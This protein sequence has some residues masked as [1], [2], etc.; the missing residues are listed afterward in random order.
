[1]KRKLLLLVL[2]QFIL[3]NALWAQ[4]KPTHPYIH[5]DC[6]PIPD[7]CSHPIVYLPVTDTIC[8]NYNNAVPDSIYLPSGFTITNWYWSP[9]TVITSAQSGT[10]SPAGITAT[11]AATSQTVTLYY[12][13]QGSNLIQN[14]DFVNPG[15]SCYNDTVADYTCFDSYYLTECGSGGDDYGH[16]KVGNNGCDVGPSPGMPSQPC[17][18][19]DGHTG[20]SPNLSLVVRG[21]AQF[22][23]DTLTN[24]FWGEPVN[25]CSGQKYVFTYWLRMVDPFTDTCTST[26]CLPEIKVYTGS[27]CGP[28]TLQYA[29][30][31]SATLIDD[32]NV[33]YQPGCDT[34]W[35]YVSDTFISNGGN[36]INM[37]CWRPGAT[38]FAIDDI[39]LIRLTY[40]STKMTVL[41]YA[42]PTETIAASTNTPCVGSNVTFTISNGKVGDVL[43][44]KLTTPSGGTTYT[45]HTMTA[46][47]W[48]LTTSSSIA[49]AGSFVLDS[50]TEAPPAGCT[51]AVNLSSLVTFEPKPTIIP[52][53]IEVCVGQT[54]GTLNF[55]STGSPTSYSLSWIT[56]G[57]PYSSG[58]LTNPL[59]LTVNSGTPGLYWGQLSVA[60][61]Y[62]C[63]SAITNVYLRV[64]PNPAAISLSQSA[65]CVGSTLTATD[66]TAG[67]AWSFQNPPGDITVSGSG[68][69]T[70]T[71]AGTGIVVYTLPTGCKATAS[72]TVN[73]LP[74]Q[75][76][77]T[78]S[79][80]KGFTTAPLFVGQGYSYNLTWSGT[81][82]GQGFVNQAIG[83][84]ASGVTYNVPIPVN[85]APG[86][87]TGSLTVTNTTTGCFTTIAVTIT[88]KSLPKSTFGSQVCLNSAIQ[89]IDTPSSGTFAVLYGSPDVAV[90]LNTGLLVGE[91]V[92]TAY[93]AYTAPNG[94]KDTT[95]ITVNPLPSPGTITTSNGGSDFCIGTNLTLYESN[96]SGYW[97]SA[98]PSVVTITG[99]T[100]SP[101]NSVTTVHAASV[102]YSLMTYTDSNI[103]HCINHNE[104]LL[105]VDTNGIAPITGALGV[106]QGYTTQLYD[107]TAGGVWSSNNTNV[108]TVDPFSGLVTGVN[109]G[110]ATITY[111]LNNTCGNYSTSVTL[112]T[113][114]PPYIT[115]HTTVACQSLGNDV[116]D[117]GATNILSDTSGCVKVCERSTV[118]YY[119]NGN[120]GSAYT[121]QVTGGTIVH[122]WGDSIDVQWNS[123]GVPAQITLLDS[124][125]SCNGA[126]SIC[127]NIILRP[128]AKFSILPDTTG[129]ITNV[130]ICRGSTISFKDLSIGDPNSPI[131]SWTWFFGD[132]G[133]SAQENPSYT[134]NT[135]GSFIAFLVVKNACNCTDTFTARINVISAPAPSITCVSVQCQNN[136]ATYQASPG[137]GSTWSVI[138]G[139]I[140][141]GNGTPNVTVYWNN[142]NPA[143]GIGYVSVIDNCQGCP[144]PAT[145]QVPVIP[146][147]SV[148][149]GPDTICEG[150][151]Y[152]YSLPLSPGTQYQ[153]GLLGDPTGIPG[154]RNDYKVVVTADNTGSFTLHGWFQNSIEL[155]GGNVDKTIVVVP[156]ATITGDLTPCYGTAT[157][158]TINGGD[159][160]PYTWTLAGPNAVT[161]TG[162]GSGTTF[163]PTFWGA[164]EYILSISGHYCTTPITINV[165]ATPP[166]LTGINGD[167]IVCLHRVYSYTAFTDSPGSVINWNIVGGTI[168]PGSGNTVTVVWNSTGTK[169]LTAYRTVIHSPFCPGT[170]YTLNIHQELINPV[171]T[172]DNAPCANS[173]R[174][175]TDNYTRG[176]TYQWSISPSTAG[177]VIAGM[178]SPNCNVM[179]NN[180]STVTNATLS[181]V[182]SKCDSTFTKT[183]AV[184]VQPS[185]IPFISGPITPVCPGTP[186]TFTASA[187]AVSYLWNFGDGTTD[188][189]TT[190]TD[191]HAF[192]LN[193]TTS[194][195]VYTVKVSL[196]ANTGGSC[197]ASGTAVMQVTVKPGP[198]AYVSAATDY[199]YQFPTT[200]VGTVTNNV[201]GF[202]YQWYDDNI[203]IPGTNQ[204]TYTATDSGSYFFVVT[205]SNGCSAQSNNLPLLIDSTIGAPCDTLNLITV[206]DS[207]SC[208]T[209]YLTGSGPY[210]SPTWVATTPPVGG[211]IVT[212]TYTAQATYDKPGIYR[213]IF[214]EYIDTCKNRIP[215]FDTI[216]FVPDFNYVVN[217]SGGGTSDSLK[218]QDHTAYLPNYFIDSIGWY[219]GATHIG[220]GSNLNLL[221]AAPSSYDVTEKVYVTGP[222]GISM[223]EKTVSIVLPAAPSI[224]FT[225]NPNAICAGVPIN[226]TPTNT[227]GFVSYSWNFGDL[228]SSLLQNTQR[229]Y[230]Y[231]GPSNPSPE[232]VVLTATNNIGCTATAT[233]TIH[234]YNNLIAGS[235][236]PGSE[237]VCAN[238]VPYIT[239]AYL[240][241]LGSSAPVSYLWSNTDNAPTTSV[242]QT[243]AYWV[244]VTDNHDCQQV[245][246]TSPAV[247]VKINF[248]HTPQATIS[249]QQTYC[250]GDVV[251]LSGYA[252][253]GVTYHWF[254]DSVPYTTAPIVSDANL[255]V[256]DYYYQLI[257]TSTDT[258]D[259]VTCSDT[260]AIFPVHIYGLPQPPTIS[261]PTVIDC[262]SYHLQLSASE[263]QNGTY[264]WSNGAQGATADI[265]SGG[266]YQ[267]WFTNQYGCVSE[268]Q[269]YV[270]LAPSY[271]FQYFPSGCYSLCPGLFPFTLDGPPIDTFSYW[272][273][274]N[275]GS[276]V[277]DGSGLM[278]PY[279]I[280]GDGSYSWQLDNGLCTQQSDKMDISENESCVTCSVKTLVNVKLTCVSG[281][282]ASFKLSLTLENTSANTTYAVGTDEGP[283][284]P[285]SGIMTTTGAYN[286][287]LTFTTL[288]T[289]P[290]P[291]SITV[292]VVLT[293]KD[294]TMCV[295]KVRVPVPDCTWQA[296]R[297]DNGNTNTVDSIVTDNKP[298]LVLDNSL[299]VF[300]NPTTGIVTLKYDFGSDAYKDRMLGIYNELGQRMSYIPALQKGIWQVNTAGWA[301]GTYVIRMEADGTNL[302]T[303]KLIVS[304]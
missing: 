113:N 88:I 272:E 232:V 276:D 43:H 157:T 40:D 213:F 109:P 235:V 87:Y 72:V 263:P 221:V 165:G 164:G 172:G 254:R 220:S 156:P 98:N 189:T 16:I 234:I 179:W 215:I 161:H 180:T 186:I 302:Q 71:A 155:C 147:N 137:C 104:Y 176:E 20:T 90:N 55:T 9:N 284:E 61:A 100:I 230:S 11:P 261:G 53:T 280:S 203:A 17:S 194:N 265:Y 211:L 185:P 286:L 267:V 227:S 168:V 68:T 8:P 173:T 119:A 34:G 198:V 78:V 223:C 12:Y 115:T 256:G 82:P 207:N 250:V 196:T 10:G 153:W 270:P 285:F 182:I 288:S 77:N 149:T 152:E 208:N 244:T 99:E 136:I 57:S 217:C 93:V 13:G 210:T 60:S 130:T 4:T 233:Q 258:P 96:D 47:T 91:A 241:N 162:S 135:P 201:S 116:K 92:G 144:D 287:S 48:S 26:L 170:P 56:G 236:T 133:T 247:P 131:V 62:G 95:A 169:Q 245:I 59:T 224:S 69:V 150:Q 70:G 54:T 146:T 199:T 127:V 291:D 296:E 74:T 249:G 112:V 81:A 281:N 14:G 290:L 188:V 226:F 35:H 184:Q 228:T 303:Q 18:P 279:T 39:S 65:V 37:I 273:W 117:Y 138:G 134:Y 45:T 248:I 151:Q 64:N 31:Q 266:P 167:T 297:T 6:T 52:D 178:Y 231:S 159:G 257:V 145:I 192:P 80:C 246:P 214:S 158:Y 66:N 46:T 123:P 122:N 304:H 125:G 219:H 282:P 94:C 242:F 243:G 183:F 289:V 101:P 89:L 110:M 271:F 268:K 278:L 24:Y 141:S 44:Y 118:R 197:P 283:V 105:T 225:A 102:G 262:Q 30:L 33:G 121:W 67:G 83:V 73:P 139:T 216:G 27:C 160:G 193:S 38:T 301:D 175:Y 274:D 124:L 103:Y 108:A 195:A 200:L 76:V 260:S 292:K 140:E 49:G 238:E 143:T 86:T 253:T 300:P 126:T 269:V 202:S 264:N 218:L 42:G 190:N 163:T 114:M 229:T 23:L 294:G 19:W 32:R 174:P 97:S 239:L 7:D 22:D 51:F 206:K 299:V 41:P 2:L 166:P 3:T 15:A 142:V 177:S 251:N 275:S 79:V 259:N 277:E 293:Y 154:A 255:P 75:T 181:V 1:M 50:V 209:I 222:N 85:P 28:H 298:Q 29:D 128:T 84:V 106:C 191:T 132:G 204:P 148:I 187:G 25:F 295:S 107:P 252:G 171:I 111:T 205:A 36:F 237:N 21:D 212:G 120:N 63:G 240:P 58:T 129:T 5:Q